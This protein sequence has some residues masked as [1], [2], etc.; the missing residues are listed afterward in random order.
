M[1]NYRKGLKKRRKRSY[2]E[3]NENLLTKKIFEVTEKDYHL[4]SKNHSK[5]NEIFLINL[6][7]YISRIH[8]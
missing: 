1:N 7:I 6:Q 2:G 8:K 4:L 3:I 5:E